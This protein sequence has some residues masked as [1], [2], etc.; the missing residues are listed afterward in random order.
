VQGLSPAHAMRTN[1][2]DRRDALTLSDGR[3]L[4]FS[5]TGPRDGLPVFYC[6]G[7]IGTPIDAT[8]DLTRIA[9]EVGIRYIAASRPGIGGSDA[10]PGRTVLDF[11]D[12]IRELADALD[13]PRFAVAGVSAG[14]PYALAVAHRLPERVRR[15]ALCSALAPFC[16]PHRTPGMQRRI[17]VPLAVLAGAPD[18][19]RRLGDTVLP[20]VAG[21]PRLVTRV[22]AAHAAPSE[23]ARLD[24][25]GERHAASQSFL[26]ATCGGVGGL[27][28]DFLTYAN[29]WG[30]S[31]AD[32]RPEVHLWHGASDPLVPVEH[33]LQL[34]AT[35]PNC[36]VFVDPDEGHHFFR[37][38]LEQIL[39]ALVAEAS[40]GAAAC[41]PLRAAA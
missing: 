18:M 16:P 17:R 29:G 2:S 36:R 4:A 11:A 5:V 9:Y 22:I 21:H 20:V 8:V 31:P 7:A 40:V 6:H 3:R 1:A 28:G 32:V 10:K 41:L 24:T 14:G 25:A 38:N 15:V 13:L 26:D 27:I 37:S 33:A 12:D 34:A 19:C 39:T 30:F 35:L 23:R